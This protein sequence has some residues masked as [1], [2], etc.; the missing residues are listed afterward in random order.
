MIMVWPLS[1]IACATSGGGSFCGEYVVID[2]PSS[3]AV[4]LER[5]YQERIL[6]NETHQFDRCNSG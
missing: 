1:L 4:K 6:A 5:R 3:E 2:M